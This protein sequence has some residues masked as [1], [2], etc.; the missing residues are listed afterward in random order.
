MIPS[1]L[2]SLR[3][4]PGEWL[5]DGVMRASRRFG[6]EALAAGVYTL[7]G[8]APRGHD[9][10]ARWTELLDTICSNTSTI[11]TSWGA[12]APLPGIEP[13]EDPFCPEDVARA[14]AEAGGYRQVEDCLVICRFCATRP[15]E[16]MQAVNCVTGWELNTQEMLR[17]GRRII[18]LLRMFNLRHGLDTSLEWGSPRYMSVPQDGPAEGRAIQEHLAEMRSEYWARMGWDPVSGVP[19]QDTLRDLGLDLILHDLP[20]TE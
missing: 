12:P 10:R 17:V 7:Q 14:N 3:E 1:A 5:A 13:L 15:E 6:Q 11:E 9:H 16:V 8:N 4:G 18:N 19:T 20:L 2:I